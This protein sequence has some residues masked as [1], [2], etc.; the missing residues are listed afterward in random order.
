MRVRRRS[1]RRSAAMRAEGRAE[2]GTGRHD[3]LR[4]PTRRAIMRRVQRPGAAEG[5]EVEAPVVEAAV[6]RQQPHGA[7]HVLDRHARRSAW[8]RPPASSPSR[9]AIGSHR[10]CASAAVEVQ[11]E[12][13][14]EE[15]V[16]VE[17]AEHEVG[18]G[19][20]G[21]ARRRGRTQAGPG[22]APALSGPTSQ[23]AAASRS[24]RSSCR[25]RRSVVRSTIGTRDGQAPLELELRAERTR[26][27]ATTP[28]SALVPPMSSVNT[29]GEPAASAKW[30]AGDQ[31]AGQAG[32][33]RA[34]TA[35]AARPPAATCA[36]V[37]L[38]QEAA[39][40][41]SR[42]PPGPPRRPSANSPDEAAQV[43]VDDHRVAAL[44]L[45]PD[46]RDLAR[47]RRPGRRAARGRDGLGE[48]PLV[49]SDRRRRTGG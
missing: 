9:S 35:G 7:G 45:A 21:V 42:A 8:R 22:S 40:S 4:S 43:G 20:R 5:D 28:T 16:R 17:A 18:V 38:E 31:A 26:P 36:A 41:A 39:G 24:R 30:L 1:T 2:A 46:R 25:R 12:L 6:G 11:L 47:D 23:Q 37:G 44:V 19:D 48:P 3:D 13:A 33:D 29:S 49:A 27:P 10:A 32:E 14:A 34:R 15:V